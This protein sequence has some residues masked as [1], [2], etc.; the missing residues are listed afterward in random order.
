MQLSCPPV[1]QL[2]SSQVIAVHGFRW[3]TRQFYM[4]GLISVRKTADKPQKR[5]SSNLVHFESLSSSYTGQHTI[6][7]KLCTIAFCTTVPY[8]T[9]NMP[10]VALYFSDATY[11]T[12]FSNSNYPFLTPK[13][14][15]SLSD[16]PWSLARS[17]SLQKVSGI[18]SSFNQTALVLPII[19]FL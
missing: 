5:I 13:I 2:G 16:R 12:P 9:E 18:S 6:K 19:H 8:Q 17:P 1:S 10:A 14:D 3:D 11:E 7:P 4:F 15:N